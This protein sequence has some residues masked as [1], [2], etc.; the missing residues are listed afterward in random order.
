MADSDLDLG[1]QAKIGSIIVHVEE[2]LSNQGHE[3]DWS[4]VEGLLAQSDV[5]EWLEALRSLALLPVKR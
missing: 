2:G 4:A 5:Q 1:L 3:F